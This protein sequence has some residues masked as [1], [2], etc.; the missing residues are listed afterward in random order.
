MRKFSVLVIIVLLVVL[1]I[2]NGW[3]G[4]SFKFPKLIK[5]KILKNDKIV[6]N[7]QFFYDKETVKDGVSALKMKDFEGIGVSSKEW[8]FTYFFNKD[9]SLYANFIMKGK[10]VV[11]EIRVGR[12]VGWDGK[13]GKFMRYKDLESPDEVK[14]EVC[15]EYTMIDLLSTFFVTS[16]KVA[17]GKKEPEKYNFLIDKGVK[18]VEIV[19][20]VK[21]TVSFQGKE[22]STD[23][24]AVIYRNT[25]LFR[26]KIFKDENGYC[27]PIN[28][29]IVTDFAGSWQNLEMRAEKFMK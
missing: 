17:A 8:L 26:L 14:I 18:I 11:S 16:Q 5:F 23:A 4:S 10:K 1:N 3:A 12:E 21:D 25:I 9:S 15:T 29:Y 2:Q 22:V 24:F 28:I 7:C 13:M 6:G 19:P 27:F 20:L